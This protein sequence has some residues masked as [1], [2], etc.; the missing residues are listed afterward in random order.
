MCKSQDRNKT[1]MKKQDN[2]IPPKA[3]KSSTTKSKY[4]EMVEM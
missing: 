1:N 2:M 4:T 3:H